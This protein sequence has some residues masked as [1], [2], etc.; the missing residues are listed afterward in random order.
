V[1]GIVAV[2]VFDS[3]IVDD[4]GESDVP[5]G[6]GPYPRYVGAWSK[7]VSGK[8]SF[9]LIECD[10]TGLGQTIDAFAD[11]DENEAFVCFGEEC[12]LID[13][14]LRNGCQGGAHVFFTHHGCSKVKIF[15]VESDESGAGSGDDAVQE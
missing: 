7:A 4:E 8:V 2:S 11:F 1:K 5:G 13:D 9:E 14:G 3:E 12:V 10:D 15:K 6:M